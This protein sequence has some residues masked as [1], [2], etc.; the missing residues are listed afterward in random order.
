MS[1][2]LSK[3]FLVIVTALASMAVAAPADLFDLAPYYPA[4]QY[5]LDGSYIVRLKDGKNF[6]E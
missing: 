4:S 1:F 2:T 3:N 5:A 6:G